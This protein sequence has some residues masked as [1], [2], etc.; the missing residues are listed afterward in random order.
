M[1]D[2]AQYFQQ[3][4]D[5]D[6]EVEIDDEPSALQGEQVLTEPQV[7]IP[8]SEHEAL[9]ALKSAMEK[10]TSIPYHVEIDILHEFPIIT[11]HYRAPR[12]IDDV[13]S[14]VNLGRFLSVVERMLKEYEQGN[15]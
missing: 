9:V 2:E 5:N 3:F 8:K 4:D 1:S 6:L 12:L 10:L 15:G 7:C 14:G 13:P 11:I